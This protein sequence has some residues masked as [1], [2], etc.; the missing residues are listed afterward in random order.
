MQ[1]S[2]GGKTILAERIVRGSSLLRRLSVVEGRKGSALQQGR[3]VLLSEVKGVAPRQCRENSVS[4]TK[5]A[6]RGLYRTVNEVELAELLVGG[7]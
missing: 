6:K 2:I 1:E 5:V 3:S 7:V 4:T